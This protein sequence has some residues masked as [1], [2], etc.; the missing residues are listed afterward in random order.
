MYETCTSPLFTCWPFNSKNVV[1]KHQRAQL[2]HRFCLFPVTYSSYH[3]HAY[4]YVR[5]QDRQRERES[6]GALRIVVYS[7][8]MCVCTVYTYAYTH[9]STSFEDEMMG[10]VRQCHSLISYSARTSAV[11]AVLLSATLHNT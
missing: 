5:R 1:L 4:I 2:D 9:T 6:S 11:A 3:H 8:W 10:L 7:M